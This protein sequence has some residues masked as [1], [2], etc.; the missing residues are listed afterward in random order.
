MGLEIHHRQQGQ[1]KIDDAKEGRRQQLDCF[2]RRKRTNCSAWVDVSL[3]FGPEGRQKEVLAPSAAAA[4]DMNHFLD[5]IIVKQ[6]KLNSALCSGV[7]IK[8][9]YCQFLCWTK[10]LWRFSREAFAL[11]SPGCSALADNAGV[12]CAEKVT[13]KLYAAPG[14]VVIGCYTVAIASLYIGGLAGRV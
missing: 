6:I 10:M 3:S 7:Q 11:S 12:L 14:Y 8:F 13:L 2:R 5:V 9:P 1:T 4:D